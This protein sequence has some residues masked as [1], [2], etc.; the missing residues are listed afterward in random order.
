MKYFK[1]VEFYHSAT[2]RQLCINNT[3]D[4]ES[5]RNLIA[6]VENVLDPAREAMGEPVW[7]NSGFRC[8]LLN[9]ALGGVPDSQH[10]CGEAADVTTAS[11]DGNRRLFEVLCSLPFDQLI[12]ERGNDR[13][14]AWVHVS[15]RREGKNRGEVL[16]L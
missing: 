12:W 8:A 11:L 13:G 9:K 2:A 4:D 1:L 7:V 10:L 14:P 16:R 15:F 5:R 3:P 6:L